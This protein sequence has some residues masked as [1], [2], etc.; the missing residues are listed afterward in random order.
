MT[1]KRAIASVVPFSTRYLKRRTTELASPATRSLTDKLADWALKKIRLEGRPFRF[2]GL[3]YLR[4]I[5]DD[6]AP[7]VVLTKSAQVGGSTYAILRAL[8]ACL[9]GLNAI[10]FFPTRTD[11][12]EFL[13]VPGHPASGQPPVPVK[14][15]TDGHRRP[16]ANRRRQPVHARYRAGGDEVGPG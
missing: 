12:L 11:V 3:E 2:E 9:T 4:A 15:M 1:K 8:H 13:Q 16:R 10:Y 6:Q 5:Y 14:Q 7:H